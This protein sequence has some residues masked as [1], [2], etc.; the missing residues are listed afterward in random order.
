MKLKSNLKHIL[1]DRDMTA[2]Q[3]SRKTGVPKTTLS[4]WLSGG[5]PRDIKKVKIVADELGITVDELCFGPFERKSPLKE[6][7]DEIFA[8]N[9][10]VILR[11][12][13]K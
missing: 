11:K 7:E 6:M 9:F 3:L 2:A 12:A 10:D 1:A 8:G 4:E 5:N 13:K